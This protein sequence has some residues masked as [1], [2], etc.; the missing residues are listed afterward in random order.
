MNRTDA[1]ALEGFDTLPD[2]AN[3]RLPVVA[4]L[5][6]ISPST[7]RRW[8]KAGVLPKPSR[9]CNVTFWNVGAL[10]AH[11]AAIKEHGYGD[12]PQHAD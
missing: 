10:R 12:R 11:I 4:S 2:A 3:V 1:L 5:L 9:V 6:G 8:S 7:V